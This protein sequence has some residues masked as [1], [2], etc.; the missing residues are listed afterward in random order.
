M[1]Y[2][3]WIYKTWNIFWTFIGVLV[4]SVAI[5][6][7]VLFGLMQLQP[8]K[9]L[10]A[11]QIENELNEKYQGVF[12]IG[13]LGG[14]LPLNLEMD[15][16]KIYPDKESYIPV[17]EAKSIEANLDV[18]SVL[19]NRLFVRSVSMD[20]PLLTLNHPFHWIRHL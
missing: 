16:V 10:V 20:A 7:G 6:T 9:N 5:L 18:W 2:I 15:D 8:V 19:Q 13:R 1:A 14:L 3:R 11:D 4:L 17:F 12:S